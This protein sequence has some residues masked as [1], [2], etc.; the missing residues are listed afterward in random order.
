MARAPKKDKFHSVAPEE[1]TELLGEIVDEHHDAL[2]ATNFLVLMKHG[3]WKSKGKAVFAK[4][5]VLGDDLRRVMQKDVILYLNADMWAVMSKPQRKYILDHALYTLDVATN[6]HG[7]VKEAADGRPLLTSVPPDIEAYTEVVKRHGIIM[8][9]VKRL[10]KAMTE[11]QQMTLDDALQF[12]PNENAAKEF[13][14]QVKAAEALPGEVTNGEGERDGV[15]YNVNGDG[16]VDLST[17]EPST[18]DADPNGVEPENRYEEELPGTGDNEDPMHGVDEG[19][20]VADLDKA[21]SKRGKKKTEEEAPI[22]PPADD[23]EL[24]F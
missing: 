6:R 9:D 24:P 5:K 2:E 10:A 11:V 23:D 4:M 18:D 16:S 22:A 1:V 19:G 7:D 21:R 15:S 12:S 8:E 20:K 14:D 13:R 3:G 17:K